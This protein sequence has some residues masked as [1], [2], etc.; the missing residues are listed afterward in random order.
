MPSLWLVAEATRWDA[1][2]AGTHLCLYGFS[3]W[4]FD[5]DGGSNASWEGEFL[6]SATDG[7][8][9]GE[10]F[11]VRTSGPDDDTWGPSLF[12]TFLTPV[13]S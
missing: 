12:P 10:I 7:P 3:A 1:I 8:L 2:P 9:A 4:R 5:D 13:A 6:F 11:R